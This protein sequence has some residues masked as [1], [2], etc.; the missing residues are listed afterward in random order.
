MLLFSSLTVLVDTT[1]TGSDWLPKLTMVILV[2]FCLV[3]K[4]EIQPWINAFLIGLL[5]D[6]ADPG[7]MVFHGIF[8]LSTCAVLRLLR[9][10]LYPHALLSHF[11][12]GSG[13]VLAQLVILVLVVNPSGM[14][15]GNLILSVLLTG[16][17]A[18]LFAALLRPF[19]RKL[20]D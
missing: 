5:L 3:P 13:V 1:I 20:S 7:S 2:W 18:G 11:L 15:V 8:A 4:S 19:A 10:W 12:A 17:C 6:G 14:Q 9:N 16:I